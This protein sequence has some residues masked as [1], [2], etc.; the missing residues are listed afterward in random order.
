M[1]STL[2]SPPR[3]A[4]TDQPSDM[5][6]SQYVPTRRQ[7]RRW[8][9]IVAAV[10][11]I[12]G[13]LGGWY[14][15]HR[16]AQAVAAIV[17]PNSLATVVRGD[18]EKN[19]TS[20]GSV[21][22]NRDVDIKCRAS[23]PIIELP[24]D[25]SDKVKVGDLLCKLDPTDEELQVKSAQAA[26]DQAKAKLVQAQLAYTQG[27][28]NLTTTRELNEATLA[29]AKV[30]A[31][32]LRAKAE[33]QKAL[34]D[35]KLGDTEDAETAETDAAAAESDQKAA[36]IAIEQLKQQEI[37]L[38]SK[39]QDIAVAQAMLNAD[40][41]ALD[42][43]KQQLDY[44][45]VTSPIDA[46]V[47]VLDMQLGSMIASGTDAVN[48]GTTIMTI[49][50]LSHIFVLATVDESDIGGVQVGQAARIVADSF[51]DRTFQGKV[52]QVGIKGTSVSNV[53]TFNV[54]VE[55]TDP[56]RAKLL[57]AM[58]CDTTIVEANASNVLTCPA[59]AIVHRG[60]KTVVTMADGTARPVKLGLQ[61]ADNVQILSGL[62]EGDKLL[63]SEQQTSR[64]AN[65]D[66]KPPPPS[67]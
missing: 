48:G 61:G 27:Q 1:V 45:T 67:H 30:K 2:Q 3:R 46:T 38:E 53:V 20:T 19:V 50:D 13:G 56:D 47:A 58:T 41:I 7:R 39:Q 22:S 24:Y 66:S 4:D 54:K 15:W 43:A 12:G 29:S 59:S 64:W 14:A 55:V 5:E 16:H 52:V 44:C 8:P 28:Q 32:N 10:L 62:S 31:L 42:N 63:L 17:D 60:E 35:Q 11:L 34:V 57:P 51:P 23:G 18:I 37:D 33:R 21:T 65:T 36:E 40:Q 25:V 26:Y 6:H 49:S 9:W